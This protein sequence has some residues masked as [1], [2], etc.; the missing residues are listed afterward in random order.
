MR[1]VVFWDEL[2]DIKFIQKSD[3]HANLTTRFEGKTYP[4]IKVG[5]LEILGITKK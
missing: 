1:D 2:N 3:K 5:W 4:M